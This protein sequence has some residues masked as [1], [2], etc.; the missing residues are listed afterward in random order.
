MTSVQYIHTQRFLMDLIHF[1]ERFHNDQEC[2][3]RVRSAAAGETISCSAE[4]STGIELDIEAESPILILPEYALSKN[5]LILHFGH[6]IIKNCFLYENQS[7]T[8]SS[9]MNKPRN[10]N[11]LLDIISIQLHDTL[12]YSANYTELDLNLTLSVQFSNFGFYVID[13]N[14]SSML[15]ECCYFNI[16]IERN[17]DNSLNHS[18]PHYSI[19]IDLFSIDILLDTYQ[20]SLIRSIL[21]YNIGEQL[22]QPTRQAIIN[23]D[24]LCVSTILTGDIYLDFLFIIQMNNVGFEIFIPNKLKRLSLGYCSFHQSFF[25]YEKYSNNNSKLNLTCTSIK[26]IDTRNENNQFHHIFTSTKLDNMQLELQLSITQIN[27]KYIIILNHVRILF[28][29]DWLIQLKNFL[30]SFQQNQNLFFLLKIK[31]LFELRLN[32]NQSELIFI[33]TINNQQ[34]NAL[35]LSGSMTLIYSESNDKHPLNCSLLDVTLFSCQMNDIQSTMVS[36]IEPINTIF[37]LYLSENKDQYVFEWNLPK[38]SIRLSY[39]DVKLMLYMFQSIKQQINYAQLNNNNNNNR[40][41]FFNIYSIRFLCEHICFYLID[42]CLNSNMPLLNLNLMNIEFIII[43]KQEYRLDLQLN[44]DYYNRL[45]SGYEPFIELWPL[46]MILKLSKNLLSLCISSNHFFSINYTKMI[47]QLFDLIKNNWLNDDNTMIFR[48][49]KPFEPYCFKNFLGQRIEFRTWSSLTQTFDLL[50]QVVEDNEIKTFLYPNETSDKFNQNRTSSLGRRLLIRIDDWEWLKPISIDC[51][52]TFF[53]IAIPSSDR[54][55][56]PVLVFIDIAMANDLMRSI[57]VRSAI[58]IQN[59]LSISIDI[60]SKYGSDL[61]SEIR[62]EPN[63][64]RSLPLQFCSTLKQIYVRP[65]DFGLCYCMEPI[66]WTEIIHEQQRKQKQE[67]WK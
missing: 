4:R 14:L 36:I 16:H 31:K 65:A 48:R 44:I 23:D 63:E 50:N 40:Q 26:L 54:L 9:I 30:S 33:Q 60:R 58:E 62:L 67:D 8:L 27:E 49:P 61:F 22:E 41:L 2:Y 51:V 46:R 6:I 43:E 21:A 19:K 24:P 39:Y 10:S 34:S 20:Y 35:V 5:V 57:T 15:R 45:L 56:Q 29:I 1:F 25:S 13:D 66:H 47:H 37:N 11:C 12:L 53:R 3:N 38:L 17:L 42:D 7:G 32:I 64:I 55:Q 28:I 59:R 52:G 18:S